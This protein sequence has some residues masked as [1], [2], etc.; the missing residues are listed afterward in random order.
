[1]NLII[2]SY[3]FL[4]LAA[5]PNWGRA[6]TGSDTS[7][8]SISQHEM[9]KHKLT[10]TVGIVNGQVITLFDFRGALSENIQR[11]AEE[12][13]IKGDSVTSTEMT[14]FVGQTWD[15]IVDDILLESEVYKRH[16]NVTDSEALHALLRSP[17]KQEMSD[18]VDS[19]GKFSPTIMRRAFQDPAN[20]SAVSIIL[21][22][23]KLDM[24]REQLLRALGGKARTNEARMDAVNKW[25]I[26]Q[27]SKGLI[28]DFRTAFGYY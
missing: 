6:Q 13:E 5:L 8:L 18:F 27:R 21:S 15:E 16:L 28:V 10:D 3:L 2:V 14:K 7:K 24:E 9:K 11:A 19:T 1:M 23:K 26:E 20:D 12:G 22:A 17:T 4:C 25:L